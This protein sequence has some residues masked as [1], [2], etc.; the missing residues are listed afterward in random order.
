MSPLLRRAQ[1]APDHRPGTG[2]RRLLPRRPR[3]GR[4]PLPTIVVL[5]ALAGACALSLPLLG[6]G[7]RVSWGQLP[8]LLA[9]DSARSALL[10]SLRTCLASTAAC[11]VLGVPLALV[12]ARQWPGVRLARVLAVLPMTMPPVVAGI[13][14]LSTLGRRGLLGARL[15][16]WGV[17]VAFSTTAVVI[18][19]V[20]VSLPYLVVTLEAALRTRDTRPETV[21]RTLGAGPWR[22]LLSITLPLVAPAL[23]RGTALALGRSLGEFGATLAFA[24]S[25]EGVTRTMPLAIYLARES[26]TPTALALAVLLIAVSFA[27]VGATTLRWDRLLAAA[28]PGAGA[29]ATRT[30]PPP[31]AER[32]DPCDAPI[33]T[34]TATSDATRSTPDSNG[35]CPA[36][37]RST[38][39]GPGP[40]SGVSTSRGEDLEVV[41]SS[42]ERDVVV[43]LLAPAGRVTALLGPN[44]SGK[45]TVCAVAAGLLDAT[46]GRVSLGGRILDGPEDFVAAGRREVALLGQAP[47]LF[48]HMCVLDNVAFGPR[49]RG[50]PRG[51]A[52]SLARSEL[53]AVG[54]AHLA[55]RPCGT[56][57]GGQAARVALARALAIRPR[58]LILDE[59][60]ASLDVSA[61]QEL[62][63]LVSRRAREEGLTVLLVT[64][65]VVDVAA[66]ADTVVVLEQGRVVETGETDH[67]LSCPG[68]DFTARLT[69]TAVLTGT[70]A[71]SPQA[72]AVELSA[73]PATHPATVPDSEPTSRTGAV[74]AA[75]TAEWTAEQRSEQGS[76]QWP[77]HGPRTIV[78]GRP[79]EAIEGF[80]PGLPGTALVP[81][82]AV[83]LY[84]NAPQG[85]PRNVLA[86]TVR[87]LER[88][89]ALV[90]VQ[91]EVA[92]G[93]RLRATV[94]AGAV[95]DLGIE[96]DQEL[97][98]VVKAV[99]VRIV[100]RRAPAAELP[101][102]P[103]TVGTQPSRPSRPSP[104]SD[105]EQT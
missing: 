34:S 15:E 47:T 97:W 11:V 35:T 24:G 7:S 49:C 17:G 2:P 69:G 20:F 84:R 43:N 16:A 12:L 58:V 4:T 99:E 85:S 100:P 28:C 60:T 32:P 18:A 71:G 65:D 73:G 40:G 103:R 5:L 14:L 95:T 46:A 38:T 29:R 39:V 21:A 102:V 36:A 22:V 105:R 67:V 78:H 41:F 10:L 50:L 37:T 93:Q 33:S 57:S 45:S 19:Q 83:A 30:W 62:R 70:L 82:D 61:R 48:P 101:Q 8:H 23:A 76:G 104:S 59:P 44:G 87:S 96:A 66:L 64:H 27:V 77:G 89:G 98:A 53:A 6:L 56:L 26:D 86:G 79:E 91:V 92:A 90:E 74:H 3:T 75:A 25:R 81:P 55:D 52:R 72:P 88:V 9:S 94:T 54:A 31:G 80:Q 68:S 1:A 63:H 13:A 51:E 42:P